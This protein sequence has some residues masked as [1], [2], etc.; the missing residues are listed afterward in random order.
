MTSPN[1]TAYFMRH[2]E[3]DA[4]IG[5]HN[6]NDA[7]PLSENG[8]RQ[9]ERIFA[10]IKKRGITTVM[11]SAADR[12]F[13]VLAKEWHP[14]LQ[15]DLHMSPFFGEWK[16]AHALLDLRRDDPE[17]KRIKQRRLDEFGPAFSPYPGEESWRD[18]LMYLYGGFETIQNIGSPEVLVLTH[19][20]KALMCKAY[21][22]A[23][24]VMRIGNKELFDDPISFT[25]KFITLFK[26]FE[27]FGWI[28][29]TDYIEFEYRK[30]FGS[31][32]MCWNVNEGKSIGSASY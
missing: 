4:N 30:K 14:D 10:F 9:A 11:C 15:L 7:T 26:C 21:V 20:H 22:Y 25:P 2:P 19:L 28:G 17:A 27:E 29:N 3:S 6:R 31:D 8:L 5:G 16:R 1:I 18:T 24:G 23:G 13:G 12:T 32:E